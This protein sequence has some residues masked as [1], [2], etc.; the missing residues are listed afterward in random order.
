ML[1]QTED[2]HDSTNP[3]MIDP[4]YWY[5]TVIIIGITLCVILM[6]FL[7]PFSDEWTTAVIG[8]PFL[9]CLLAALS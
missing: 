2:S 8:G 5:H 4:C 1:D 3:K 9:T 6:F 7:K